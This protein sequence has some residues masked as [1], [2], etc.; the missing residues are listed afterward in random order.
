[1]GNKR[2]PLLPQTSSARKDE[3]SGLRSQHLLFDA[4]YL[5]TVALLSLLLLFS[6]R[7][8]QQTTLLPVRF[9][10]T[11][12]TTVPLGAPFPL[13]HPA[14][15]SMAVIHVVQTNKDKRS[16]SFCPPQQS[17]PFGD[18]TRVR[19]KKVDPTDRH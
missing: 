3:T 7:Y 15:R 16:Y 13:F 9:P 5:S 10:A 14:V 8:L 11:F 12:L 17:K 6:H 4:N 18:Q 2:Q 19:C 1:M